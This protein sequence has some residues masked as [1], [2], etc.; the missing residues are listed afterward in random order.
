MV[1]AVIMFFP[2]IPA[3]SILSGPSGRSGLVLLAWFNYDEYVSVLIL[4]L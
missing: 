3:T 2:G 1:Q 4:L